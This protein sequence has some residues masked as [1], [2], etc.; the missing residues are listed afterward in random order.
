MAVSR[1]LKRLLRV[2]NLEEDQ[3][4]LALES[5]VGDL[6]QLKRALSATTVRARGGRRLVVTSAQT[7]ELP[8]R[9]AG[10]EETY[11]AK[12]RAEAL[13]PRIVEAESRVEILRQ[14][15]LLK[16]VECRQAE[17]L[18]QEAEV[19]D[20]IIAARRTQQGLDDWYLNRMHSR[21]P[22]N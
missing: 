12:R 4:R 22:S 11:A 19:Q 14:A 2:L 3:A 5:A 1:A 17:T 8:D 21:Q 10:L 7:G 9:L 13:A 15:F 6:A 20:A 16:R 18:I